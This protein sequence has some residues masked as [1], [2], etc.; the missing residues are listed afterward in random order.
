MAQDDVSALR[1]R[2]DELEA[3]L[4]IPHKLELSRQAEASG[5]ARRKALELP[6]TASCQELAVHIGT[7]AERQNLVVEWSAHEIG[8]S[9]AA[10]AAVR[11][12]CCCCCCVGPA[13]W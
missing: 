11:C 6:D 3:K 9:S 12:C 8:G 7:L 13:K 10:L 5:E 1:N 4:G 2:V